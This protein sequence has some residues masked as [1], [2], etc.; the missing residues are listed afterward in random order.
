M[1]QLMNNDLYCYSDCVLHDVHCFSEEVN[2]KVD[3][4]NNFG[5]ACRL[6]FWCC[7]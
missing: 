5:V 7:F 6:L 2:T 1:D 4:L 3:L